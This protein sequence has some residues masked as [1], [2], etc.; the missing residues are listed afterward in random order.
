M[1]FSTVKVEGVRKHNSRALAKDLRQGKITTSCADT[2]LNSMIEHKYIELRDLNGLHEETASALLSL[3][4]TALEKRYK[5]TET[6][7]VC[8]DAGR[9][10]V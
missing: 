5:N 2:G 3:V 4:S 10:G 9:A 8:L 1:A 7:P 6:P